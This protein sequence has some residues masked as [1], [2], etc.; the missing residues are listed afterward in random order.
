MNKACEERSIGSSLPQHRKGRP[1]REPVRLFSMGSGELRRHQ[2]R[3]LE[4]AVR[5]RRVALWLTWYTVG[6][7]L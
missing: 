5:C 7:L 3:P 1:G 2:R 4:Q 6:K